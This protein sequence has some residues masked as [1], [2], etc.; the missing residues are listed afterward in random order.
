[1]P[2]R[3]SQP[4]W[5]PAQARQKTEQAKGYEHRV[6]VGGRAEDE[7][8]AH[9]MTP[10]AQLRQLQG[11]ADS[12][13]GAWLL[14]LVLKVHVQVAQAVDDVVRGVPFGGHVT[15]QKP[16]HI[17]KHLCSSSAESTYSGSNQDQVGTDDEAGCSFLRCSLQHAHLAEA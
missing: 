2:A 8:Q 11:K 3:A 17:H 14:H 16:I 4:H 13:L 15:H 1:M 12:L 9:L 5:H 10:T 6:E 7:W